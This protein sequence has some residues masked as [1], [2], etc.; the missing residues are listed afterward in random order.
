MFD[1]A[2]TPL[3]FMDLP[4]D[5]V[6]PVVWAINMYAKPTGKHYDIHAFESNT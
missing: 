6:H 3:E 2:I 4:L 1:A 5:D